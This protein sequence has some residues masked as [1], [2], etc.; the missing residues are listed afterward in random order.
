LAGIFGQKVIVVPNAATAGARDKIDM[1]E[2]I[3]IAG[4]LGSVQKEDTVGFAK[5]LSSPA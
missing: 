5:R 1:P 3:R 2:S 4:M